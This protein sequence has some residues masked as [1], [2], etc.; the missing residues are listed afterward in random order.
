MAMVCPQCNQ[1]FEQQERVCPSCSVHLLFYAR[2]APANAVDATPTA[3]DQ[4]QQTSWGRVVVAL[5]LAQGLALGLKQLL[6]AGFLAR[7]EDVAASFGSTLTGLL[8]LHSLH[9]VGL[10][11][12]GTLAGAGQQRGVLYGSLAGLGSGVLF[13]ILQAQAIP[14]LPV[15][16]HYSQPLWHMAVGAL[17]GWIGMAIWQPTLVSVI[18]DPVSGNTPGPPLLE[19]R[20]LRGPIRW[21][22]VIPGATLMAC[23][24]L[25]SHWIMTWMIDA[26]QGAFTLTTHFQAKLVSWEI[27]GL[28]ML[29]GAVFA[30]STTW[31]GA[32]QGL[33]VG[34][35]AAVLYAGFQLAVPRANLETTIA[36]IVCMLGLGLAGG[37][38]G[39]QLFPP[40]TVRRRR[41]ILEL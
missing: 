32:K 19:M 35:G 2:L 11:I 17:G 23:G 34:I 22:R 28:T 15:V 30:G 38:F 40:I 9:A 3:N 8:L 37:W 7:G 18:S 25:W 16:V 4:W 31:N 12:G 1:I 29:V 27:A 41:R 33:C 14:L 26:S 10:L 6:T 21:G 24:V 5:I 36:G 39:G 13:M 20:W